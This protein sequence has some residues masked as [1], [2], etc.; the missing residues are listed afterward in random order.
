V[1]NYRNLKGDPTLISRYNEPLYV[2]VKLNHKVL[3]TGDTSFADF[4]IVNQVNLNGKYELHIKTIDE[5]G[6]TGLV[7]TIPVQVTGG[8]VYGELLSAG[9]SIVATRPGYTRIT[10]EL[11]RNGRT[12][13]QGED[14]IYAVTL[15][16]SGIPPSGMIADTSGILATF[17]KAAGIK[18]FREFKSG[19]PEGKYL[20]VG[21]FQPQQTGNPLVTDILE[22]VNEGNTLIIVN[23]IEAWATHLAQ[24]EVID[25]RGSK[26]L[27]N[28][29]YGGNFFSKQ[30][31]LFNGLP[32]ARVFNWEY[33]CF[34]TYSRSRVGLRLFNGEPIV[35]CV[36]DHKK[37]VYSALSIIRHG[38]GKIILC[39]L[40]IFSC[41]RDVNVTRRAEGD[42]ENASMSTFNSSRSNKANIVG[43]QLLLNMLKYAK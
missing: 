13:A 19:R 35:A 20:L 3:G 18:S 27:G 24:K 17:L 10:A 4:F 15:D 36:A 1:D 31:E 23:N 11:Q 16:A 38:R 37:E 7:K 14:N 22:W 2:A 29:W 5:K 30:H 21:A 41:L 43:Q 32:Q 8:A 6:N 28:T 25:Y 9:L 40:D 33:Q 26:V 12:V 39:S 42:G 34:A